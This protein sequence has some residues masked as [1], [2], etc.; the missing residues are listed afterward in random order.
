[1]K[2]KLAVIAL[3]ALSPIAANAADGYG[4]E[5]E[6]DALKRLVNEIQGLDNLVDEAEA[7]SQAKRIRFEYDWLRADLRRV[8]SGIED[9]LSI[10]DTAPRNFPPLRGDYAH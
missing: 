5:A 10:P 7:A 1:M 3:L 4:T 2:R 6:R 9:A 8:R